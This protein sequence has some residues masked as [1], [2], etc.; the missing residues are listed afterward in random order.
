MSANPFHFY[1]FPGHAVWMT[2]LLVIGVASLSTAQKNLA[3]DT[4]RQD[5]VFNAILA[6]EVGADDYG[7]RTYVMALLKSGPNRSADSLSRATLQRAHLDNII[8][9]AKE[10][11]LV[12]AGPFLDG[13]EIRG[14]YVFAVENLEEAKTLTETDPAVQAGSLIMELHPWYGAAGLMKLEEI[15][16]QITR[17]QI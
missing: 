11:K 4:N 7:M 14:I 13:G 6:Q 2:L 10:G 9:L 17:L 8:R 5:T 12:L 3:G 1:L 15:Q 16:K